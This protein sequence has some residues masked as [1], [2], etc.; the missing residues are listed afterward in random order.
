MSNVPVT[1]A[2]ETT[3]VKFLLGVWQRT[4]ES[5]RKR[6][7]A[8]WSLLIAGMLVATL[9]IAW[10]NRGLPPVVPD[11]N[12]PGAGGQIIFAL[13]VVPLLAVGWLLTNRAT[14]NPY[15]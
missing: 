12:F 15:G 3:D 2:G 10:A 7:A 4:P 11:P 8:F 13:A 9:V 6:W 5:V 1:D 14:A